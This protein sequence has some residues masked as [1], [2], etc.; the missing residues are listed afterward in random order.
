MRIR[1]LIDAEV[2]DTDLATLAERIAD[3]PPATLVLHSGEDY[4]PEVTYSG[5]FMG[6]QQVMAN[7]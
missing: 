3:Q 4:E 1:F 2:P 7:V 5:R 6:A